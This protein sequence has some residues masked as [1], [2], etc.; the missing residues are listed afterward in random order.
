[1]RYRER[2]EG[3]T[4]KLRTYHDAVR[5]LRMIVRLI[6][7][8]KPLQFFTFFF[9][10]LAGSAVIIEIPV[11]L[12]YLETAQ[13]PRLPTAIKLTFSRVAAAKICSAGRPWATIGLVAR[14]GS[15]SVC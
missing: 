6:K 14:N 13:V 1:M 11:L 8:E 3:S 15:G 9:V 12:T 10:V 2:P 5:I 4:S 7:E